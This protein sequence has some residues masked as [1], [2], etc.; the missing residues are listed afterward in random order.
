MGL[1]THNPNGRGRLGLSA[2]VASAVLY[3][4]VVLFGVGPASPSAP[5]AA[6]DH[7]ASVVL[8]SPHDLAV[9]GPAQRLPQ[10]SPGPTRQ[11]P[12]AKPRLAQVGNASPSST[13]EPSLKN[14]SPSSPS[15]PPSPRSARQ[16]PVPAQRVE[17]TAPVDE[18]PFTKL[19]LPLVE[20]PSVALPDATVPPL[21][22][23]SLPVPLPPPVA[24]PQVPP[25]L[26]ASPPLP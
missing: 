13:E 24:L 19:S 23:V 15:P 14:P 17:E 2:T 6:V 25:L 8:A 10:A 26:P 18:R 4:V 12:G 22:E 16:P 5:G 3:S 1:A 11:R 9:A 20:L 7:R 21:P